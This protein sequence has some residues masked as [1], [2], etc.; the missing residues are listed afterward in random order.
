MGVWGRPHR[1]LGGGLIIAL[2]IHFFGGG[3]RT[4]P[5]SDFRGGLEPPTKVTFAGGG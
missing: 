2:K 1:R 4:Y 5:K 3:V